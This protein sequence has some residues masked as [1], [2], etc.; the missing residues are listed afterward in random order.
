[1]KN[2]LRRGFGGE[3]EVFFAVFVL[4]M[5]ASCG[6]IAPEVLTTTSATT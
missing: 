3:D 2:L 5:V 4:L 6:S 1:M